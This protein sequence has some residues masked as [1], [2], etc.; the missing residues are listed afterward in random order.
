[1]G[2]VSVGNAASCR[3]LEKCGFVSER[4]TV[5]HGAEVVVFRRVRP[6]LS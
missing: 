4:V 2:A 5:Y 1:V 3:V 6:V